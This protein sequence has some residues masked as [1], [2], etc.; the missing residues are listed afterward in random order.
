MSTRILVILGIYL[1]LE[2]V[3]WFWRSWFLGF[4]RDWKMGQRV[5]DCCL[6]SLV[7]ILH[8]MTFCIT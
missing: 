6:L 1:D 5:F 2:F 4:D 8:S 3:F 7:L